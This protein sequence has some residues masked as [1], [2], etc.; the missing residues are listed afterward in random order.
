V[1]TRRSQATTAD[2]LVVEILSPHVRW[3]HSTT[4]GPTVFD[5]THVESVPPIGQGNTIRFKGSE[6]TPLAV[7]VEL[8]DVCAALATHNP[9]TAHSLS[10]RFQLRG[11]RFRT[12]HSPESFEVYRVAGVPIPEA[13]ASGIRAQCRQ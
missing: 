7:R 6:Q 11:Y 10:L 9:E 5:L 12:K 3:F 8:K 2:V 13:L 4:L 1:L